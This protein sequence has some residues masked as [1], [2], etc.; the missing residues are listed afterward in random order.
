MEG[1]HRLSSVC[2]WHHKAVS[3]VSLFRQ[4]ASSRPVGCPLAP[5]ANPTTQWLDYRIFTCLAMTQSI[6]NQGHIF[7]PSRQEK[8]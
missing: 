1:M 2:L 3:H 5:A 4:C 8:D 7:T 6:K